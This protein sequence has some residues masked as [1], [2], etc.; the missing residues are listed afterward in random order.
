MPRRSTLWTLALWLAACAPH[1]AADLP[2]AP[3]LTA[4]P[5]ASVEPTPA[6]QHAAAETVAPPG[7]APVVARTVER[8]VGERT[9]VV[10]VM[11]PPLPLPANAPAMLIHLTPGAE[12]A[13]VL[14][15]VVFLHG[16]SACVR[17]LAATGETSCGDGLPTQDGSGLARA[18]DASGTAIALLLPQLAFLERN[19][20]PG[21]LSQPNEARRYLVTGFERG[22][23]FADAGPP[24]PG[25]FV[26]V[27][28]S[29]AFTAAA[30][31]AAHGGLELQTIVLLDALYGEGPVCAQWLVEHPA[32]RLISV[33]RPGGDPARLTRA[34]ARR[35]TRLLG[36]SAVGYASLDELATVMASH[37]FVEVEVHTAHAQIPTAHLAAILRSLFAP[38][39]APVSPRQRSGARPTAPDPGLPSARPESTPRAAG[40]RPGP[41]P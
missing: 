34:L 37:R 26:L 7:T 20:D 32:A 8:E 39:G 15:R 6:P 11:R 9:W 28:H 36:A 30:A 19:G 4:S 10:P 38:E 27:A 1:E 14:P 21:N 2:E 29:G 31:I 13:R 40:E 33:H 18:A 23:A 24:A 3:G 35:L 17:A 5:P 16:Y 25:P 22:Y 41:A 12:R